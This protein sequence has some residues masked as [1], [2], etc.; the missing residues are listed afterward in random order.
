MVVSILVLV[1]AVITV[2]AGAV[3]GVISLAFLDHCPPESCSVDAAV[4]AVTTTIVV[5][6]LAGV[7]GLVLTVIRL[8]TRAVSWPF[9]VGTLALVIAVLFVGALV[10]TKAVN[11]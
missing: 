8:R 7:V 4:T 3:M 5:A 2:G 6:A 1:A 10:Y 11:Y 9:A